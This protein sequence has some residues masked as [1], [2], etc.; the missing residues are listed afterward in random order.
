MAKPGR[1]SHL[2]PSFKLDVLIAMK[3]MPIKPDNMPAIQRAL[4]LNAYTT[5]EGLGVP[6]Y[7]FDMGAAGALLGY[8]SGSNFRITIH[9]PS[10]YSDWEVTFT[11]ANPMG[12][13][14]KVKS[15]SLPH[16]ICLAA[17]MA[18]RVQL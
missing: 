6:R 12:E 13:T 9:S 2:I 8:I 3:V 10:C 14:F 11:D 17:L 15:A 1:F 5:G 18:K 16:A 4:V 7:S